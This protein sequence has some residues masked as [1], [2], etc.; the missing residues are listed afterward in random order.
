MKIPFYSLCRGILA[1]SIGFAFANELFSMEERPKLT[2][3]LRQLARW[4]Q[5]GNFKEITKKKINAPP[6]LY[7]AVWQA[8]ETVILADRRAA[9]GIIRQAL[10]LL[11]QNDIC[12]DT[13]R[14][15]NERG[16]LHAATNYNCRNL[17]LVQMLID[18]GVDPNRPDNRNCRP[19]D[20]VVTDNSIVEI[21]QQDLKIQLDPYNQG[22]ICIKI[23]K[24]QKSGLPP[25]LEELARNV[26]AMNVRAILDS[27]KNDQSHFHV[28]VQQASY[29][30]DERG[31]RANE[32][33]QQALNLLDE[34][35]IRAN[36]IRSSGQSGLLHVAAMPRS[37]NSK[38]VQIL[39]EA[40]V[41]PNHE[42]SRKRTPFD[43]VSGIDNHPLV[44]VLRRY[45]A[46]DSQQRRA[47]ANQTMPDAPAN[48]AG[49][50]EESNDRK[51]KRQSRESSPERRV[52]QRIEVQ[53]PPP[54][55][56]LQPDAPTGSE[57]RKMA[58]HFILQN[59]MDI[60]YSL[61]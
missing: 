56:A 16:L 32:I 19:I 17:D 41:D 24:K 45:G 28:A 25:S 35:N 10:D 53:L 40:G 30:A 4:T 39:L 15:G 29:L 14:D 60:S 42:N 33:I 36:D 3:T 50:E 52:R 26:K 13:I 48:D 31:A 58:I 49:G 27:R 47:H 9:N 54:G 22:A 18:V 7:V 11:I 8:A 34:N 46:E 5:E 37:Q 21:L 38:L 20:K 23:S 1:M 6:L 43:R 44:S 59:K 55:S 12:P 51:R 2:P 57:L 61:N